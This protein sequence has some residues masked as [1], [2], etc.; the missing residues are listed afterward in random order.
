V[1]IVTWEEKEKIKGPVIYNEPVVDVRI[2]REG[3]PMTGV[4]LTDGM[5]FALLINACLETGDV[6]GVRLKGNFSGIDFY[7]YD[8][9]ASLK[10]YND[11]SKLMLTRTSFRNEDQ[12]RY[13]IRRWD[14]DYTQFSYGAALSEEEFNSLL[15]ILT[16]YIDKKGLKIPSMLPD[17]RIYDFYELVT[18]MCIN[19]DEA[20]LLADKTVMQQIKDAIYDV[21][22]RF[23]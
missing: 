11:G 10:R 5:I 1:N 14:A 3:T 22:R 6:S 16:E 4:S 13:D 7:I 12:V 21:I 20:Y 2:W 18:A 17:S 8:Q 19:L 9:I 15:L 23:R